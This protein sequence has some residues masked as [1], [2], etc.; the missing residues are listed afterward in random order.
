MSHREWK[1]KSPILGE[2]LTMGCW[3]HFGKPVLLYA[4]ATSDHMDYEKFKVIHVLKPLI[5]A[6]R[7]KVYCVEGV[8]GR[9]WVD[10]D[11]GPGHKAWVQ[12][13]F[14]RYVS[15]EIV[16]FIA[17]DCAGVEGIVAAGAS[18]GAFNA[19][20]IA[21]KHPEH[22][23]AVIGMSGTYDYDRW[24]GSYRDATYYFNAPLYFLPNMPEGPLLDR[25]RKIRFVIASGQG[26]AEAAWE[27]ERLAG[28]LK[29]KGIPCDLQIWAHDVHHDWPTWRTMLP[30]FLDRL[31]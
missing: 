16:P 28:V 30:M 22:F 27:S 18:L 4:T 31:V 15:E 23:D 14:D 11:V 24:M 12:H 10:K 2:E 20:S 6:G 3:G 17:D 13:L 19:V 21:A 9:A 26:R 7:I 8:S 29:A 25:L 1:W 5:E